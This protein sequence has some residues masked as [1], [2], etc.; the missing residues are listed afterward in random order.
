MKT[1]NVNSTSLDVTFDC[2]ECGVRVEA[3]LTEIP[4]PNMLAEHIHDSESSEEE[5][6]EC[7]CGHQYTA[8]IYVNQAEGNLEIED[9]DAARLIPDGN[10]QIEENY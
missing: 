3:E 8:H 7:E 5:F 1:F 6:I 10:I 4:R 2:V 9:S